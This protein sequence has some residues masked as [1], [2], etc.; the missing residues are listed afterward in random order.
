[1]ALAPL[2]LP[3]DPSRGPL[4]H[5]PPSHR[6]PW[7]SCPR[8][9]PCSGCT[10]PRETEFART[11]SATSAQASAQSPCPP[12]PPPPCTCSASGP[13]PTAHAHHTQRVRSPHT[14]LAP[15]APFGS[16]EHRPPPGPR[17]RSRSSAPRFPCCLSPGLA[18]AQRRPLS[19]RLPL[20]HPP[21]CSPSGP[22]ETHASPCLLPPRHSPLSSGRTQGS[23][24]AAHDFSLRASASLAAAP[25]SRP[26]RD[27]PE[28]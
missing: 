1:M 17:G 22:S 16:A 11:V 2:P 6:R 15:P 14:L 27:T 5:G 21:P 18:T 3:S 8:S 7:W 12:I 10:R 28:P 25:L 19:S 4:G 9:W 26:R 13:R 24:H 23:E 20:P